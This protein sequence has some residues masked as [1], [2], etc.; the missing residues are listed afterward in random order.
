MH[1]LLATVL[2]VFLFGCTKQKVPDHVIPPDDMVSILVDIH[3]VDGML[4][5]TETRRELA[6]KDTSNLYNQ[7]LNNYNYS[8]HDF[9][10][11]LYY[12]SKNIGLYDK[13]Y[14]E[15]LNQLNELETTLKQKGNKNLQENE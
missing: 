5:S 15:V 11:S 4:T 7:L 8:R 13:V 14:N 2:I 1:K 12:Y 6:N 10:T 9:D 3:L